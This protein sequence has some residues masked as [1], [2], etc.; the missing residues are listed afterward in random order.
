MFAFS[1]TVKSFDKLSEA[2]QALGIPLIRIGEMLLQHIRVRVQGGKA[3]QGMWRPLGSD[4]K[5]RGADP[6]ARWWVP[7][8]APHPAGWMTQVTDGE[9]AGWAV[10]ESYRR[11]LDSLP[12]VRSRRWEKS[13]KFW[14]STAVKYI[15]AKRVKVSAFGTRKSPSGT[16]ANAQVGYLAGR[17]ERFGVFEPSQAEREMATQMAADILTNQMRRAIGQTADAQA[18]EKRA[19]SMER[20]ASKLLG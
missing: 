5:G 10:Y 2:R 8:E 13:G 11:Y 7:P 17:N 1:V 19:R 16:A 6:T 12:E 9:Y 14:R 18:F 3:P 20:R 4:T 15:S